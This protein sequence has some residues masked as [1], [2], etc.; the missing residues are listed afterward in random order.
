MNDI[1][2][3]L[4]E[5]NYEGA[6]QLAE[7]SFINGQITKSTLSVMRTTTINNYRNHKDK[8]VFGEPKYSNVI[9]SIQ[10]FAQQTA[11]GGDKILATHLVNLLETNQLE[12]Y[13]ENIDDPKY[14]RDGKFLNNKFKKD[15]IKE[16]ENNYEITKSLEIGGTKVFKSLNWASSSNFSA[17]ENAFNKKK[18]N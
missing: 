6:E 11:N 9:K 13:D 8:P 18:G 12:W 16:F 10:L 7:T 2:A 1:H 5:G 4:K 17:I 14:Y 3:L 15:F